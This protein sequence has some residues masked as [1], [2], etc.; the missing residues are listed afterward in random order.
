MRKVFT[1]LMSKRVSSEVFYVIEKETNRK[2]IYGKEKLHF[3]PCIGR[4]KS[5]ILPK[6]L[7]RVELMLFSSKYALLDEL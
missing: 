2:E 6:D 1:Q 4:E 3:S 7:G 5:D